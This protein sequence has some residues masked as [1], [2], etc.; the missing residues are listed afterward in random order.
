MP[1][2]FQ[3]TK[4]FEGECTL[5]LFFFM[6]LSCLQPKISFQALFIWS[7]WQEDKKKGFP[8]FAFTSENWCRDVLE[9]PLCTCASSHYVTTSVFLPVCFFLL[10]SFSKAFSTSCSAW[11][12][13]PR[14]SLSP[15]VFPRH[16]ACPSFLCNP[17][18][19]PR[20]FLILFFF[21]PEATDL[22]LYEAPAEKF[23]SSHLSFLWTA[24][25]SIFL[26]KNY[27][28][29]LHGYLGTHFWLNNRSLANL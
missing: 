12:F 7:C 9:H 1:S 2:D 4:S 26:L 20:L 21:Y 28:L 23:H 10:A 24:F 22:L 25:P 27:S 11:G 5:L 17:H 18:F 29:C 6:K 15:Q 19:G 8:L 14:S 16:S 13:F 3:A